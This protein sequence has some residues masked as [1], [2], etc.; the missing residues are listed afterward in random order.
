LISC[1]DGRDNDLAPAP[2]LCGEFTL[3]R[4]EIATATM[5]EQKQRQ[6]IIETTLCV[7]DNVRMR[8]AA[9]AR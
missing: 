5:Q 2:P 8:W 3:L 6:M 1:R 4:A 9:E 7:R